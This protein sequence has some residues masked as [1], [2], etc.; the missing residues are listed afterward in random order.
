MFDKKEWNRK[1]EKDNY[2]Y[3]KRQHIQWKINN[4]EKVIEGNK[5]YQ[6]NNI[7]RI[8]KMKRLWR[9][10]NPKRVREMKRKGSMK[11]RKMDLKY[12]LNKNISR[13]IR[14]SLKGNKNGQHWED[15]VD[16]TIN[17]LIKRLK[18][19]MPK[20]YTWNDYLNGKLHVDHKIPISAFNFI[21]LEN[22]DFKKCWALKNLR[23]LPVR[24]NLIK[25]NKLSKP[26]QPA[27]KISLISKPTPITV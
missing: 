21:K 7:D 4:P 3:R 5:R 10:N 24:E 14:Y 17:D 11:R 2:E 25:G 6:E 12:N 27:L 22:P 9:L 19:T 26:F 18:K 16:Y 13:A 23:L 20:G 1:W 15:L 8:R